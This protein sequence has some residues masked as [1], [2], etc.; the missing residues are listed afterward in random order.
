MLGNRPLSFAVIS[1]NISKHFPGNSQKVGKTPES[2][3]P[4]LSISFL[5]PVLQNQRFS[6]RF[7][8]FRPI[9]LEFWCAHAGSVHD[10][11]RR[12]ALR[13]A[14]RKSSRFSSRAGSPKHWGFECPSLA[15]I[16][17]GQ[18]GRIRTWVFETLSSLAA[19]VICGGTNS[20][21]G[22]ATLIS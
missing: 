9:A 21:S 18:G 20:S 13:V 6:Q 22:K 15:P 14:H 10:V 5:K 8:G 1:P 11:V 7:S 17:V 4:V 19:A 16:H 2:S 12:F 3:V